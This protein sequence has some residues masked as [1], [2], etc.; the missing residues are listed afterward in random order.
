[1]REDVT[2]AIR[3]VILRGEL[4]LGEKVNQVQIAE[5]LGTSRGPVREALR[6]LEEEGLIQNIPYHI[7]KFIK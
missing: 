3:R 4:A 7:S 1:M 5:R 2:G 6:Q